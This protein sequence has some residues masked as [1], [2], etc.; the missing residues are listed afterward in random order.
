MRKDRANLLVVIGPIQRVA[1]DQ[2]DVRLFGF[3]QANQLPLAP[4]EAGS[5]QVGNVCDLKGRSEGSLHRSVSH[6]DAI[7]FDKEGIY[8]D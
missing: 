7:G 4:P 3:E 6:F 5:M 1:R 8:N 2:D